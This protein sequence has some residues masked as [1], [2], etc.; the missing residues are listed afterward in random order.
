MPEPTESAFAAR[1]IGIDAAALSHMLAVIGV[2]SLEEMA[3]KALPGRILDTLT[4]RGTAP[5]LES[6]PEPV[7]EHQALSELREGDPPAFAAAPLGPAGAG[8]RSFRDDLPHSCPTSSTCTAP[9]SPRPS[10][11]STTRALLSMRR[12]R[13]RRCSPR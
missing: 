13:C 12:A 11:W 4:D 8:G 5:G 1:H 3:A 6:L 2:G 9:S 10:P 7:G